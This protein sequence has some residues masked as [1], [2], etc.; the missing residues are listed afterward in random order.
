MPLIFVQQSIVDMR[1]DAIVN[2]ANER[3]MM[4]GGVCGAIFA[5][6]G[7]EKLTRACE[8]I[9]FCKTGNAVI[10]PGFALPAAFVIHAVGPVW[11]GGRAGEEA[12]LAACYDSALRLAKEQ[13]IGSIAFPL[14]SSGIYGFPKDIARAVAID[15]IGAFLRENE[16]EVYLAVLDRAAFSLGEGLSRSIHAFINKHAEPEIAFSMPQALPRPFAKPKM[17][18]RAQAMPAPCAAPLLRREALEDVLQQ[19]GEGFSERL[20]RL[21]D[22]RGLTDVEVYQRANIDRRLFSKIRTNRGYRPAKNTALAFAVA[23]RLNLDQTADLLR[24][25]GYALSPSCRADLIVEYFL[26][27]QNY[28]IFQI[29]EALF[30]FEESLLGC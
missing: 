15:R 27:E 12:L 19:A 21:I 24:R 6:A 8:A 22:E 17:A 30:A 29:N 1:V 11:Q 28:D 2:A 13:G 14:I 20:L 3:L 16:L 25:A 9:G 23:L 26:R 7:A 4:G 10:T 18:Q 5:A